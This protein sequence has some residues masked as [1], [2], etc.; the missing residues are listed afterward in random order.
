MVRTQ[1]AVRVFGR[2]ADIF[3]GTDK[4]TKVDV[5]GGQ[6]P[7]WDD[8]L[9]FPVMKT[10]TGKFRQ[11]EVTCFAKESKSD[12]SLGSGT[13]D[14]TETLKTG[15]FDGAL[16]AVHPR[17]PLTTQQTGSP[18]SWTTPSAEKCTWR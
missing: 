2:D 1:W 4:R 5:K 15:E 3:P 8:E 11:L 13:L 7:V 9:R 18:S 6:H 16:L 10:A 14:I 12:D 17:H